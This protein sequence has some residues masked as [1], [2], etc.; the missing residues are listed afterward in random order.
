MET[1]PVASRAGGDRLSDLPDYLLHSVL[2]SLRSRQMVQTCLLSRRW[3]HL[4]RSVPC[5]DVDQ[6]D[7][8]SVDPEREA[9]KERLARKRSFEDFADS[10]LPLNGAWPLDAYRLHV[11]DQYLRKDSYR[12]IRRGLAR[13][14]EELGVAYGFRSH[15]DHP[16][17]SFDLVSGG[18]GALPQ[19][20]RLRSPHLSGL[21][22]SKEFVEE[23]RSEC[24][25]LEELKL[26]NC[27][28]D[29][30]VGGRIASRS[31][32]RLHIEGH[33]DDSYSY[34]GFGTLNPLDMPALVSLN[35]VK[36]HL[37]H[38]EDELQSLHVASITYPDKYAGE[39]LFM[40]S[41]RNATVLELRSF[42]T[43]GLLLE[44]EFRN[45][46][47][48]R[49]LILTECDIGDGCQVLRYLLEN[50]PNLE[51]LVLNDCKLSGRCRRESAS[52]C[53]GA[54]TFHWC[55]NLKHIQVQYK[56]HNVPPVLVAALTQIAKDL[57][58][59]TQ[60]NSVGWLDWIHRV[61]S[62]SHTHIV[63]LSELYTAASVVVVESD[64]SMSDEE[65]EE[66]ESRVWK[67]LARKKH[68]RDGAIKARRR[69]TH[70]ARR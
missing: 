58:R 59:R 37:P 14:P 62:C 1:V 69:A 54:T 51:T 63:S 57:V 52:S 50:V 22:L 19:T 31:L 40:K 67:H 3:R 32:K 4:W 13:R 66:H 20:S 10:V 56:D 17:F 30:A 27:G 43:T 35:L 60:R 23:L 36:V 53:S 44:E 11:A 16:S 8:L 29:Y 2:S 5:L 34:R 6:R 7:F 65:E 42:T 49:T 46:H 68:D 55:N 39:Y 25:V 45:F 70:L 12:W 26:V 64:N 38:S 18:A 9:L 41:L 48:L 24:P 47:N 28:Y 33:C 15:P 61:V 21:T